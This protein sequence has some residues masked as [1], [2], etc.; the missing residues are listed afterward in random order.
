MR[1]VVSSVTGQ[2][3][4]SARSD[5]A[6]KSRRKQ[7][8]AHEVLSLACARTIPGLEMLEARTMLS[9]LPLPNI[10]TRTD[11]SGGGNGIDQS[12]P[13]VSYDPA[14]SQK[15]VA[16]Y[17]TNNPGAGGNQKVFIGGSYSVN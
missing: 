13:S 10:G 1:Y 6:N 9:T 16:V 3:G 11:V 17:T 5:S 2:Q 4:G 8:L 15:P 12:S 7:K 14:N